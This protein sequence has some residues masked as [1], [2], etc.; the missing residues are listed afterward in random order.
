MRA[1]DHKK[2]TRDFSGQPLCFPSLKCGVFLFYFRI[3]FMELA[4]DSNQL[5]EHSMKTIPKGL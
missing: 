5:A 3:R 4:Q 1:T 2:A